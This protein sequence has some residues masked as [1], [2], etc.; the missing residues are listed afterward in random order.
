MRQKKDK[1]KSYSVL[2]LANLSGVSPHTIR[3]W[4]RRYNALSPERSESGRRMY[5]EADL[6]RLKLLSEAT[7]L[8]HQ[9]GQIA[10]LD[11]EDL[12]TIA[13][14]SRAQAPLQTSYASTAVMDAVEHLSQFK[15]DA[16]L[17]SIEV[18]ERSMS[19]KEFLLDFVSPLFAYAGSAVMVD[20]L[21][22]AH[23]HLL[24]AILRDLLGRITF[25]LN[26]NLNAEF[27]FAL[28]TPEGDLHEFGILISAALLALNGIKV[29]YLGPNLPAKSFVLAAKALHCTHILI[30]T[31]YFESENAVLK[32]LE[33]VNASKQK[34]NVW[35]GGAGVK[36]IEKLI[37]REKINLIQGLPD[38]VEKISSLKK[39]L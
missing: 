39:S 27:V 23:E 20:K 24:S 30:G 12:K 18:A 9:I 26:K 2:S 35:I 25:S 8:G 16:L 17:R 7:A 31:T 15:T 19:L 38:L 33:D 28:S 13:L 3:I 6:F 34:L 14:K 4:E 22:V 5:D 1:T 10:N 32:Y 36:G 37:K 29:H 21:T 11:I